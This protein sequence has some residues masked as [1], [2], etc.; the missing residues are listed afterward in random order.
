MLYIRQNKAGD[1]VQSLWIYKTV[2]HYA[3]GDIRNII[4]A[5]ANDQPET[6]ETAAAMAD[7]IR[8][9]KGLYKFRNYQESNRKRNRR[10]E[11]EAGRGSYAIGVMIQPK[12]KRRGRRRNYGAMETWTTEETKK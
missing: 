1:I 2:A 9:L 12:Q 6:V 7:I 5:A 11:K 3:A 8:S 4:G 10:E